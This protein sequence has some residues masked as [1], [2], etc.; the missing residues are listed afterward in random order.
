ML[1]PP[2]LWPLA[3]VV[4]VDGAAGVLLLRM[5][6][7]VPRMR[8]VL[9][10][11]RKQQART[12]TVW[13]GRRRDLSSVERREV[14]AVEGHSQ[15][16]QSRTRMAQAVPARNVVALVKLLQRLSSIA[17]ADRPAGRGV[18]VCSIEGA[19]VGWMQMR[20]RPWNRVD[21]EPVS[22]RRPARDQALDPAW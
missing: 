8:L 6:C 3:P 17:Q 15:L 20:Q 13:A 22:A 16:Q 9:V 2:L 14:R 5:D 12:Q 10:M 21:R 18:M 1:R 11:E 19:M 4:S 7:G